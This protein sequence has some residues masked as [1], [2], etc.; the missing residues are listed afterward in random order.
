MNRAMIMTLTALVILVNVAHP[1]LHALEGGSL[2]ASLT[3]INAY[4]G[5]ML[6]ES[7]NHD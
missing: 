6:N 7:A 4:T 3:Y 1:F 2:D 5:F